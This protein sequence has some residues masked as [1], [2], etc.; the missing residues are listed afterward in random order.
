MNEEFTLND[1]LSMLWT[2]R[3]VII[4]TSLIFGIFFFC[5]FNY[6]VKETYTANGVLYVSNQEY[7]FDAED[8]SIQKSDIESA[9]ALSITYMETLKTRSFLTHISNI[10]GN[11]YSW[12][13][14]KK[15]LEIKSVNETELL[16]VSFTSY[17]KTDAYNIANA[18][19]N[20]ASD[21]LSSVFKGGKVYIVDTVIVPEKP[22][23]KNTFLKT[24][25]GIFVGAVFSAICAFLIDIYDT[26]IH[27]SEDVAN[28]YNVSILGK[29]SQ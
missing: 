16:S 12:K 21:K 6:F 8:D 27:K 4:I 28:R 7:Q 3:T 11:K 15:K 26:K 29:I 10:T 23:E 5:Y 13:S 1:L 20:N 14:I 24:L 18:I 9:R 17:S 25:L 22:D 2:H 19:I